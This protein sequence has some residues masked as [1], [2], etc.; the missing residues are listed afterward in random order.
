MGRGGS[1]NSLVGERRCLIEGRGNSR[2]GMIR[3]VLDSDQNLVPDIYEKL[4]GRGVWLTSTTKHLDEALKKSL[5][6]K[7]FKQEVLAPTQ[8]A[9]LI[10]KLLAE[11]VLRLLSLARKSGVAVCGADRVKEM[12]QNEQISML[13]Q[14]RDG[15]LRERRNLGNKEDLDA[16]FECLDKSELGMVF[17]RESVVHVGLTRNGLTKRIKYDAHRLSGFRMLEPQRERQMEKDV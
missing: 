1:S 5:F 2:K 8:L 3:F 13:L 17:G 7:A 14:A 16:H 10:E 15:S 11:K 12:L 4:G 6:G 9:E